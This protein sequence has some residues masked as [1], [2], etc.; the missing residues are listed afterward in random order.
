MFAGAPLKNPT[1]ASSKNYRWKL[2]QGIF[3]SS[4][5]GL[6]PNTTYYARAYA[7]NSAGTGYGS[8]L[9]FTTQQYITDAD[10]NIYNKVIIGTQVWMKEKSKKPL[11]IMMELQYH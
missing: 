5:T 1:I 4:I 9:T 11:N 6:T 2:G 3:V 7:T 10:G 8:A